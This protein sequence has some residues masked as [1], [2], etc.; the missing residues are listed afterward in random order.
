MGDKASAKAFSEKALAAASL[1]RYEAV[2][3]DFFRKYAQYQTDSAAWDARYGA[4]Y[5]ASQPGYVAVH[6]I[7]SPSVGTTLVNVGAPAPAGEVIDAETGARI[8]VIPAP[9]GEVSTPVVQPVA[10]EEGQ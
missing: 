7:L 6:S 3:Q 1:P 2:F 9:E 10:P 5:G 8:P 4:R